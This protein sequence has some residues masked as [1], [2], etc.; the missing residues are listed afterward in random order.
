MQIIHA[1]KQAYRSAI[2]KVGRIHF[3]KVTEV[4]GACLCL[5]A[6]ICQ[7]LSSVSLQSFFLFKSDKKG[8]N[9]LIIFFKKRT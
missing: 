9:C 3:V 8:R 1:R 4:F 5:S 7:M 2:V 6:S